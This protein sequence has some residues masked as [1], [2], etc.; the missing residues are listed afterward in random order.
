[1]Y[2]NKILA[3]SLSLIMITGLMTGCSASSQKTS[4]E[5]TAETS[6]AEEVTDESTV[7]GSTQAEQT[8]DENTT[9]ASTITGQVTA[10]NGS[11]ITLALMPGGNRQN[12]GGRPEGNGNNT[13]PNTTAEG[14]TDLKPE[15]PSS[16][17]A[18]SAPEGANT[19]ETEEKVITIPDD[20]AIS[21]E[22]GDST[23]TG[24]IDDITIGCMLSITYATDDTGTEIISSVTVRNFSENPEGPG[25]VKQSGDDTVSDDDSN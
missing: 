5:N 16:D 17:E 19:A 22:D 6:L 14:N 8:T 23:K 25:G 20:A 9:E 7:E 21:I 24:T 18:P 2:K 4:N 10:I 12:G 3:L 1:M 13:P 11:D 15:I